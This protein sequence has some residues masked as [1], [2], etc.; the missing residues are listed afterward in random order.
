MISTIFTATLACIEL[1]EVGKD[2]L[3]VLGGVFYLMTK[4]CENSNEKKLKQ[5]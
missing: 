2:A 3:R 4:C 1:L 5:E